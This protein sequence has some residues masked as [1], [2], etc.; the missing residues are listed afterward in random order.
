MK[1]PFFFALLFLAATPLLAQKKSTIYNSPYKTE[2]DTLYARVDQSGTIINL[3]GAQYIRKW[4]PE[5]E[6][7]HENLYDGISGVLV[8]DALYKDENLTEMSGRWM[9]FH[10]NGML[11]DSGNFVDNKR[12]GVF[13]SWYADGQQEMNARYR[14]GY[15]TDSCFQF[16]DNGQLEEISIT[17]EWGNGIAQEY[18]PGGKIR[19]LGRLRE[20]KREE[21][22]ILKRED[23]TR[24]MQLEYLQDSITKT[25]CFNESGTEVL[26]GTCIYEKPAVFPGGIRA[27]SLY[28]SK[29]VRYPSKAVDNNIEAIVRVQFII[30]KEGKVSEVE[31]LG[32]VDKL[33]AEEAVKLIRKSPKWEPAIQLNKPVIY[34]HIQAITFQLK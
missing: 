4:W 26:P 22:W 18:Y 16:F 1:S 9:T 17:D 23:G 28:I 20:G 24:L 5:K 3:N 7:W 8:R 14:K 30:D 34:R 27:W 12:E 19:M 32:N 29:N 31:A 21:S 11:K 6:Q 33:L 13:M 15:P 2:K 10:T 25:E